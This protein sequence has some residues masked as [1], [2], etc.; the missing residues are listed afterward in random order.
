MDKLLFIIALFTRIS[1][2]KSCA[3]LIAI[4]AA[5][6]FSGHR[7]RIARTWIL[8]TRTARSPTRNS[9]VNLALPRRQG[10]GFA[11]L[12]CF[13]LHR[14]IRR[15]VAADR[16]PVKSHLIP[17]ARSRVAAT[18]SVAAD[19]SRTT[20]LQRAK[21]ASTVRNASRSPAI[22][23]AHSASCDLPFPRSRHN[24]D[25]PSWKE[26]SNVASHKAALDRE[27]F[28]SEQQMQIQ[29]AAEVPG[30]SRIVP[31]KRHL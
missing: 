18:V 15:K 1:F 8:S 12:S 2:L 22:S 25:L 5:R 19:K 20:R 7:L 24:D 30:C 11:F 9:L 28:T 29:S 23:V 31:R 27:N 26:H 3:L 6:Y 4:L 14:G 16:A 13:F 10:G 21:L 17:L